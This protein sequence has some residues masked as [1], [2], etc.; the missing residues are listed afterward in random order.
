MSR[1]NIPFHLD[2]DKTTNLWLEDITLPSSL[3]TIHLSNAQG[4]HRCYALLIL[5]LADHFMSNQSSLAYGPIHI[6]CAMQ[7]AIANHFNKHTIK[8]TTNNKT[9]RNKHTCHGNNHSN[10]PTS[11]GPQTTLGI[12]S[13]GPPTT[14]SSCN[15]EVETRDCQSIM[16]APKRPKRPNTQTPLT[17]RHSHPLGHKNQHLNG[18][19]IQLIQSIGPQMQ[20]I[21]P[22]NGHIGKSTNQH[23]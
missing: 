13:M 8:Q 6:R 15:H 22:R 18:S 2:A 23:T 10:K 5:Y 3:L 17:A 20:S 7:C 9:E 14:N 11:T 21:R 1:Y 4:Y 16:A 12:P 19:L